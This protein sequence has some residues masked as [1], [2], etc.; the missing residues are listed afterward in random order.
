MSFPVLDALNIILLPLVI[1]M[2][3][4]LVFY[5]LATGTR[6]K[7][8]PPAPR[9]P[10][11]AETAKAAE[12]ADTTH[13]TPTA[14]PAAPVPAPAATEFRAPPAPAVGSPPAPPTPTTPPA[15]PAPAA[16]APPAAGAAGPTGAALTAELLLVD[17][18]AVV[19]TMLKRLFTG[20]GYTVNLAK[21]GREALTLLRQGRYAMLITDLEMP[22]MDGITLIGEMAQDPVLQ[23]LPILAIT[24]HENLQ[25]RL[26]ACQG[27]TGIH[28][29]PWNDDD[30][31]DHVDTVV[32]GGHVERPL[33]PSA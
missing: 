27:L 14:R 31:L 18:S 17:D 24:G 25:D 28:R 26:G 4:L 11:S 10:A 3:L 19:R 1:A 16:A 20:A 22:E 9:Q 29:K 12:T 7:P 15:W 6:D 5:L 32:R 2:V 30:L 21:D 13:P 33:E 23:Q 8:R